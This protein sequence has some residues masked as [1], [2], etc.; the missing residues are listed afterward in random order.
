M[1]QVA[2]IGLGPFGIRMLEEL[3]QVGSEIIILDRDAEKIEK[4]KGLAKAA[5][6]TDVI[7]KDSFVKI[8]PSH[9]DAAIVDFDHLLEPSLL[10]T[11]YLHQ[12]GINHI[13]VQAESDTYGELLTMAGATQIVYPE[14]EA[15]K[16]I[17][18]LLISKQLCNYI[19]LSSDFAIAEVEIL[20]EL[21]GKSLVESG[22]RKDFGLNVIACRTEGSS[23]F[24]PVS[25]PD[26]VFTKDCSILVAGNKLSI[27]NYINKTIKKDRFGTKLLLDR[28]IK[29]SK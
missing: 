15:A 18:P 3:S 17:T 2:I 27:E 25:G 14:Y 20:D 5:Y 12:M 26:F 4:Y 23:E 8:I 22:I 9:I 16:R 24:I 11:H 7:N 10:S 6:I 1:L 13:I 29:K 19:Q 28:F 21:E